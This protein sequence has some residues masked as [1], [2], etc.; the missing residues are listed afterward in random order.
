MQK[1]LGASL[2]SR[3]QIPVRGQVMVKIAATAYHSLVSVLSKMPLLRWH[4]PDKSKLESN[5]GDCS[6]IWLQNLKELNISCFD[7]S[8]FN[9]LEGESRFVKLILAKSPVLK[10]VI[11]ELSFEDADR[12]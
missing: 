5:M 6:D 12:Q 9:N 8:R 2:T 7:N 4:D 10:K 1:I 11:I 3:R